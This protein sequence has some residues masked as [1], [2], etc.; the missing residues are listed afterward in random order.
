MLPKVHTHSGMDV[1]SLADRSAPA[2][3]LDAFI[4]LPL[5]M[6]ANSG[7]NSCPPAP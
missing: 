2:A 5:S 7:A 1:S 4:S 6:Q 3:A